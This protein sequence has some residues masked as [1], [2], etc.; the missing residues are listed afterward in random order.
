MDVFNGSV[1]QLRLYGKPE[2]APPAQPDVPTPPDD[3]TYSVG[4]GLLGMMTVNLDTPASDETFH[5][6]WSQAT[7][8]SGV[9]YVWWA[10]LGY[11]Q[12]FP[13]GL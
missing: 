2:A 9:I 7:G 4:S 13:P 8:E 6:G 1:D 11:G 3:G 12:M 10:N 5:T